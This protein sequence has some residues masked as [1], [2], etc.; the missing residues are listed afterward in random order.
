MQ[1][2]M[3]KSDDNHENVITLLEDPKSDHQKINKAQT[4]TETPPRIA[5]DVQNKAGIS[6]LMGLYSAGNR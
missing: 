5:H 2:K 1:K 6:N 3:S 4:D